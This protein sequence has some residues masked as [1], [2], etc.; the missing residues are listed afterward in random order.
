MAPK[1]EV[2]LSRNY[3]QFAMWTLMTLGFER[4]NRPVAPYWSVA[5]L[6]GRWQFTFRVYKL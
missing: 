4:K 3:N 2:Q 5:L 6:V 1:Y